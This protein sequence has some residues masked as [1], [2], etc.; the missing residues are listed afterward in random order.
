MEQLVIFLATGAVAGV[1]AGL[2]GVG[3]G[4]II[5][6]ALAWLLPRHGVDASVVMQLAIGTSLAVISATS[7]SSTFAHHKRSGVLWPILQRLAPGLVAGAIMG[8]FVADAL[9]GNALKK[10]VGVGA[11]L[12]ALQMWLDLK[13]QTPRIPRPLGNIEL[14]SAGGIIG[15]LAALI[16]I[17]GGSLTVPYLSLRGISM[18][19]AVGTAAA[20]GMPIAWAG[21]VGFMLA[22]HGQ[23]HLPTWTLGYVSLAGFVGIASASVLTAPIG[24][25][26]AHTLPPKALK[27]AFALMLFLIGLGML[28]DSGIA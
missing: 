11:L 28:L 9:T 3:G 22:G 1:L 13:P 26:L 8:G 2:F 23:A 5:V 16:G 18:R 10:I 17:G 15:I 21:A 12:V 14:L 20:A 6:P 7:I 19:E 4:L 24:A 25:R 27:R